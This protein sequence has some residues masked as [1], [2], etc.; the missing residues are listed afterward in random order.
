[1]KYEVWRS[2]SEDGVSFNCFPEN[3]LNARKILEPG[4]KLIHVI[5]AKTW[6]EAMT[7]YHEVMCWEP[8]VPMED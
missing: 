5:E 4:A 3:S 2:E 8:Y 6:N 7:K 1:M